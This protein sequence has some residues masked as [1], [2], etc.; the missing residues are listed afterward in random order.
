MSFSYS[1]RGLSF[2]KSNIGGLTTGEGTGDLLLRG[3]GPVARLISAT[4]A[5]EATGPLPDP[6]SWACPLTLPNIHQSR[7]TRYFPRTRTPPAAVR[8]CRIAVVQEATGQ[9]AMGH[10]A[11]G[12]Q[13]NNKATN[14][15]GQSHP[16]LL[17]GD[18]CSIC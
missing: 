13:R 10:E 3:Y 6:L 5:Y 16:R 12:G 11:Q 2:H 17:E 15:E 8:G 4:G 14:Q 1:L 18:L 7:Q 9:T